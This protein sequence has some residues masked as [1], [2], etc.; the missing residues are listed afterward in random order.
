[1]YKEEQLRNIL[2]ENILENSYK[3]LGVLN[4]R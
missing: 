3:Y 1:M 2:F 4:V